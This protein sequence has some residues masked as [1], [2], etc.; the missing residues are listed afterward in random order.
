ML[1]PFIFSFLYLI[2]FISNECGFIFIYNLLL[3]FTS[4]IL[5]SN[6][7]HSTS[8]SIYC[9]SLICSVPTCVIFVAPGG[10]RRVSNLLELELQVVG[11]VCALAKGAGN[12]TSIL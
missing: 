1:T 3:L 4:H 7:K 10:Q 11:C 12:Q 5:A 9:P 6:I 2:C 8:P